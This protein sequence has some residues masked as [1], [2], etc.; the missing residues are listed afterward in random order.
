[1]TALAR[2]LGGLLDR[3]AGLFAAP[4]VAGIGADLLGGIP[5]DLTP[6]EQEAYLDL[7]ASRA[8]AVGLVRDAARRSGVAGTQVLG[9]VGSPVGP[10]NNR[11]RRRVLARLVLSLRDRF[12]R[13]ARP[14]VAGASSLVSWLTGF[15]RQLTVGHGA[16]ALLAHGTAT[17]TPGILAGAARWVAKQWGY[18]GKFAG[19]IA[20]G[21][22]VLGKATL[23]RAASYA[24]M[25]WTQFMAVQLEV[26]VMQGKTQAR[27]IL[28]YADH[29]RD[30]AKHGTHGCVELAAKGWVDINTVVPIGQATCR[31]M[32]HCS[33]A[34]Q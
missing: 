18:A 33:I 28:G 26:A 1:M 14:L 21:A 22:H 6:E 20:T 9:R 10:G 27:R 25:A 34:F 11:N 15:R 7:L 31:S 29:C 4:Q 5:A 19:Q 8:E 23:N 17:P 30:S 16:A 3:F 12:A 2:P 24:D 32:C 13:A